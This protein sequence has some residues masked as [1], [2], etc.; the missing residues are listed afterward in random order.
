MRIYEG[1]V[2]SGVINKTIRHKRLWKNERY[3]S[4]GGTRK[5]KSG[6]RILLREPWQTFYCAR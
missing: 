2:A 5:I 3:C 4:V 6:L 1:E